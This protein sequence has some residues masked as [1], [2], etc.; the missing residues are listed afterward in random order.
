MRREQLIM[1]CTSDIA[2]QVRGKAIPLRDLDRRRSRGVGWTPTNIMI[3]AHGP[4]APSPWGAF[5]DLW[6]DP[7]L[8]TRVDLAFGDDL[9]S[10]SFVL[11]D[12]RE[13]DGKPW[14]CCLRS[15]LKRGLAEL[16]AETGLRL[17]A[18]FEHEFTYTGVEEAPN[19]S[20]ALDAFRRQGV[21]GECLIAA[22]RA[23]GLEPD[24]F[25]PEYGP[26]Q[27]EITIGPRTGVAAADQAVVLR[28][29]VRGVAERLGER[30][31]FTPQLR[32]DTVG[33]GVHVHF[34]LVDAQNRSVCQVANSADG[35]SAEAGAFLAGVL[36]K[37][38]ALCALTAAS[39]ISYM[40]LVPHKWSA[41]YN[42][43]G[44]QDRE[45]GLR[46]CPV[47]SDGDRAGQVHFEYRAADASASPYL[48]LGGLVW[49]G[50]WGMRNKLAAPAVTDRDPAAMTADELAGLGL[51]RLPTSLGAALDRLEA[52]TDVRGWLGPE[53]TRAYLAHK[54]FE[55]ELMAD[56][57]AA[58][59]CRRYGL[60]Y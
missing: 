43:L 38:P 1:I 55:V 50:L 60:A 13:L 7:D 58:E 39:T 23:A 52:D 33:N 45:A 48:V 9:A 22:L 2:G 34:S 19:A 14:T 31:S 15:F 20:Y 18:A 26:T 8:A 41:A 3:T 12:V 30:A 6:L 24:T 36:A 49:A 11:A 46:I 35:M 25:M 53:L 54:R 47:F 57:D 42:N 28:E 5:G 17:V 4:I 44:R 56:A 10:E 59:Q 29:L 40:R 51:E 21:F 32:P 27:Y 37:M 16:E